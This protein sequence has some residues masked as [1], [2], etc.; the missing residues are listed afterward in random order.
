MALYLL[1][2]LLEH[3]YLPFPRHTRLKPLHDL[4]CPLTS[5]STRC[6]LPAAFM[7]VEA[8]Q[9]GYRSD[10]ICAFVHDYDC[11]RAKARL[12]VLEGIEVHELLV[13]DG[14]GEDRCG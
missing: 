11:C 3:I 7:L 1:R 2:Q 6:T 5:F 14:L 8:R 13:T 4:L 12:A 10:D 9:P